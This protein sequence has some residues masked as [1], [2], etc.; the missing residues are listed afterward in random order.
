[1]KVNK[2]LGNLDSI[3]QTLT[4]EELIRNCKYNI[5]NIRQLFFR[6]Y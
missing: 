2:Y 3:Y 1:M 5:I 4:D 6:Y